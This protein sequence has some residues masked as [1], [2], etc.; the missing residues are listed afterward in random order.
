MKRRVVKDSTEPELGVS[1]TTTTTTSGSS[2][3]PMSSKRSSSPQTSTSTKIILTILL[4]TIGALIGFI[5]HQKE[6]FSAQTA[7]MIEEV[8]EAKEKSIKAAM[9]KTKQSEIKTLQS[10]YEQ[11]L[12]TLSAEKSSLDKTLQATKMTLAKLE[13]KFK[14]DSGTDSERIE[15]LQHELLLFKKQLDHLHGEMQRRDK[16]A[17]LE[18]FGEGPHRVE[19]VVDFPPEEVPEGDD[20]TFV[21]ETAP[22]E[23]VS[24]TIYTS[25]VFCILFIY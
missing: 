12:E 8:S 21:V 24:T 15:K 16:H 13:S 19:F 20:I 7:L 23:L 25:V 18:E 17:A 5:L 22:L 9:D 11:E 3:R 6:Q 4:M 1:N 14:N 2:S 10:E